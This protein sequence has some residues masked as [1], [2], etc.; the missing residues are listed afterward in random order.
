MVLQNKK[1]ILFISSE[2]EG[3]AK[4]GGLAD[5]A[6]YLPQALLEQGCEIKVIIPFYKCIAKKFKSAQL[7]KK[8]MLPSFNGSRQVVY[9]IYLIKIDKINIYAI[10]CIDYFMR[11]NL[12]AD[13]NQGYID[14]GERFAFFAAA[15]LNAAIELQ[16]SADIVHCND[17]HTAL[18]PFLLKNRYVHN[19]FLGNAK[20]LLTIHNAMF[21]GVF[22]Y[23]Q[24]QLIP[25]IYNNIISRIEENTGE[26]N[27][28]KAGILF[29]DRINAVSPSYACELL[30]PEGSHGLWREFSLRRDVLTG[31]TNGCAYQ[32]WSPINDPFIAKNYTAN[33]KSLINGKKACKKDLQLEFNLPEKNVPMYGMVCR[34][35]EQKGVH[36]LADILERFL[37]N[38]VQVV[39]LGT[40]DAELAQ[41]LHAIAARWNKKMTFVEAYNNKLAHKIE[42]GCDFFIM[43]SLFEPCGLNQIYSL[44]YATVPIVRSVG[45]LKDTVVDFS[46]EHGTG[47]TF[48]DPIAIELLVTLQRS[49][50][51]FLQQQ[52]KFQQMQLRAMEQ[53]FS[54]D[55][56]AIKYLQL[57]EKM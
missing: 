13:F 30:S 46:L 7:V 6:R 55:N 45:G 15:A 35:T 52:T 25:E 44:S 4:T 54:W 36:L 33:L 39:I 26:I 22:P 32:D 11:D 31:I 27:F 38:D 34:L 37:L 12:Y 9:N 57:Y 28:L 10:D 49:L 51:V 48:F 20:S 29:A 40:G 43:P 41:R 3:L 8:C 16:Y 50:L 5:V 56:V 17:W 21:Q 42:A 14:N 24:V 47:F 1:K 2:I 23:S 53:D 18:V 19:K